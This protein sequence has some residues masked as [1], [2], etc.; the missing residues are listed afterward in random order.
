[1]ALPK[2]RPYQRATVRHVLKRLPVVRSILVQ[3]PVATGKTIMFAALIDRW[4]ARRKR[5]LVLAHREELIAQACS[6]LKERGVH[7][8]VVRAG[9][10]EDPSARVQVA[11]VQTAA[12]RDLP[13][14][15]VIV[16]DEAHHSPAPSY[17]AILLNYPEAQIVGF[18]ATPTYGGVAGTLGDIFAE[19]YTAIEPEAAVERGYLAPVTGYVYAAP[20]LSEVKKNG[21]DYEARQLG[22]AMSKRHIVGDIVGR[23]KAHARGVPT[24]LFAATVAQ[25]KKMVRAFRKAGV[26]AE[27][28][29]AHTRPEDR[30]MLL[31]RFRAGTF[32]VLCNV[33][34][35]TEGTDIEQV[36]CVIL[37]RPTYSLGLYLQMQ[38]RGRR[39][40]KGRVCRIHDHGGLIAHHN[41][42]DVPRD[43][44]LGGKSKGPELVACSACRTVRPSFV[45]LCPGCPSGTLETDR[46]PAH[47]LRSYE[48]EI[49][50][51][52]AER[53][54]RIKEARKL[55]VEEGLSTAKIGLRL[56]VSD[57]TVAKWLRSAGVTL[58][59]SAE[60]CAP[61]QAVL[62]RAQRL[63]EEGRLSTN[64]IAR[65]LG[66]PADTVCRWPRRYG[67][68]QRH[69]Q[70]HA[71]R[72][73]HLR[74]RALNLVKTGRTG[75][76]VAAALGCRYTTVVKWLNAA[77]YK[78]ATPPLVCSFRA[79]G[80]KHCAASLCRGHY[81]QKQE[82]RAL[83]PIGS[84]R[85]GP[86]RCKHHKGC[87][88]V[89]VG[90]R[91]R[92]RHSYLRSRPVT[93]HPA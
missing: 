92:L 62:T 60:A 52:L 7:V 51:F 89:F 66:L 27:H 2:L 90:H 44:T 91:W 41:G 12:R 75:K 6:R 58:R 45:A 14:F 56:G 40:F 82:G 67:W 17:Q 5:V 19:H 57:P 39:P 33:G 18:T 21:T 47:I 61:D 36:K 43:W 1:M 49:E 15:D 59:S 87:P 68:P 84:T 69:A 53:D 24:M 20:S 29:D 16:V 37:A 9:V 42:P 28:L 38:G 26:R 81:E 80:R 34:L 88:H 3:S 30:A 48:Y 8:G 93:N 64:E 71:Q 65:A 13:H 83:T 86:E 25:S 35:F 85:S 50:K 46:E 11:S 4:V 54:V 78:R 77:G 63:Y 10:Q 55:Y 32:P 74:D 31:H 76:E 72:R 73:A 22:A 23:W 70:R 79:C